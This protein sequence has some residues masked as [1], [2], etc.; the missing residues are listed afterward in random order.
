MTN[1]VHTAAAKTSTANMAR[2]HVT[3]GG[4]PLLDRGGAMLRPE[5]FSA[6]MAHRVSAPDDLDYFPT[7]PW[8]AR[9]GGELIRAIDPKARTCW[10]PAC[11]G[12]HMVHGLS[13]YFDELVATDIHDHGC[14]R[15]DGIRDFLARQDEPVTDLNSFDWIVTN[16]PFVLG[17]AF[18][19]AAWDRAARGVAMLLR[20][21]FL[22]G[23][24]RYR[25]FTDVPLYAVAPF[26]E[27]VPMV[28][29]RWDPAASSATAYAWFIWVKPNVPGFG[30][31]PRVAPIAPGTRAR[32]SRPDDLIAFCGEA[33]A[34][35]FDCPTTQGERP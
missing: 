10:E 23:G 18:V 19:R 25:L 24:A 29:G 31:P 4:T 3:D 28:K 5:G 34:P 16:P 30:G 11:G 6:V 27:R 13:D 33:D 14:Q 7:P 20:L 22:E 35:L 1:P 15:L 26:A 9:A 21:Q 2:R 32:L 17:E 12:G 8:A